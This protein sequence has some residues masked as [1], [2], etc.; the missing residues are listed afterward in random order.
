MFEGGGGVVR[1]RMAAMKTSIPN[2]SLARVGAATAAGRDATAVAV[3]MVGI[4]ILRLAEQRHIGLVS[5]R[6][7]LEEVVRM[8]WAGAIHVWVID[9]VRWLAQ[10]LLLRVQVFRI[11]AKKKQY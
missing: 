3:T 10:E 9:R 4:H 5:T 1:G 7:F 8:H 11:F 6:M 2:I